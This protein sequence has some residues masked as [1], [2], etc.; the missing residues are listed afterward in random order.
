M[1]YYIVFVFGAIIGS[2]LNVCIYRI[3]LGKS[4]VMPRSFCPFCEKTIAWYDNVPLLSFLILGA[5]CRNCEKPIAFRYFLVELVTAISGIGLLKYYFLTPD[6]FVYWAFVCSLIVVIFIDLEYQE[7]PD[8][9]SIPGIFAGMV[10]MTAFKLDGSGSYWWSFSNSVLGILVGGGS[11]FL[12]GV[13]G[14]FI[15]KKEALGG[16][17]VKLMAMIG[18]FI[19]WKAVLLTFFMAPVVGSVVGIVMKI[20]FKK[21]MIAYGP[22]LSLAAIVSLLYGDRILKYLFRF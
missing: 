7:I 12:L 20:K 17:D 11:M 21:D 14:E 5:K 8:V 2:F 15:F 16:G 6:F 9:I 10:F 3:P 19:G 22:Y 13:L 1:E 18:A 4:V